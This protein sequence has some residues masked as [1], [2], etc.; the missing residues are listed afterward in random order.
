MGINILVDYGFLEFPHIKEGNLITN[1]K[2]SKN[3]KVMGYITK[4]MMHE[5]GG[6]LCGIF[7]EQFRE[8]GWNVRKFSRKQAN[9]TISNERDQD[10]YE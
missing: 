1:G 2:C 9:R 8:W 7:W 4:K 6:R 10:Y 3:L 5:A